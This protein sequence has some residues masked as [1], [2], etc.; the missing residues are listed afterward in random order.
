[1]IEFLFKVLLGAWC[2]AVTT[3]RVAWV[4]VLLLLLLGLSGVL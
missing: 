2:L 3:L 4:L 1:V